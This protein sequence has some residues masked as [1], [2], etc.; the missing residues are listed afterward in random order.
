MAN[1]ATE[2]F[3]SCWGTRTLWSWSWYSYV[4][5]IAV[6]VRHVPLRTRLRTRRVHDS[7]QCKVNKELQPFLRTSSERELEREFFAFLCAGEACSASSNAFF[8]VSSFLD[9]LN[10]IVTA[11]RNIWISVSVEECSS[12][13]NIF[14]YLFKGWDPVG[15]ME[16]CGCYEQTYFP[17]SSFSHSSALSQPCDSGQCMHTARAHSGW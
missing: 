14:L 4:N 5:A 17:S 10:S 8:V 13:S 12:M 9:V 7:K 11:G 3:K 1:S 15:W 16:F 2:N 6:S